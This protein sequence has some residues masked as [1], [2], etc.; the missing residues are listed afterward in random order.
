VVRF[1]SDTEIEYLLNFPRHRHANALLD[2]ID[3]KLEE[4]K[5]AAS[6]SEAETAVR[7]SKMGISQYAAGAVCPA[8]K[9]APR[10]SEGR[11]FETLCD[12]KAKYHRWGRGIFL[13]SHLS[14]TA[15]T[16]LWE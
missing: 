14:R 3:L 5:G 10:L 11:V 6:L 16:R 8:D 9:T 4:S 15:V 1:I 13:S 2:A 7:L 12:G